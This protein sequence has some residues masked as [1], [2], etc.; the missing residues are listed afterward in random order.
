MSPTELPLRD[1]HLPPEIGLFPLAIGW[2]ILLLGVPIVA[3]FSFWLYKRL[4]R[5]TAVKTAKK[6]LL[7]LKNSDKSTTEKLAELAILL[8]RVAISVSSRSECASL[9]GKAWLEYLDNSLK[10]KAFTEGVGQCLADVNYR[11]NAALEVDMPALWA[12]AE[13]W[14][15][16]QKNVRS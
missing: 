11:K 5:K 3:G 6:L 10:D 14:L 12:L 2:W 15:K 4:T 13:R 9:T 1:I 16:A 8:R 7:A